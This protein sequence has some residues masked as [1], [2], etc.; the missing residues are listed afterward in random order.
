VDLRQ[1]VGPTP[2]IVR[3]QE[4]AADDALGSEYDVFVLIGS[5]DRGGDFLTLC[6]W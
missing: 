2:Y 1:V 6:G 3:N 4:I 5:Q